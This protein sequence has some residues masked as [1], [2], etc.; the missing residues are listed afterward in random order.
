MDCTPN[1]QKKKSQG[2][3]TLKCSVIISYIV[4]I[5]SNVLLT[6]ILY[7]SDHGYKWPGYVFHILVLACS[8]LSLKNLL[9]FSKSNLLRYKSMTK[10]Y[11]ITLIITA[12]FYFIVIIYMFIS[13][14]DMDLIYYFTFCIIIWC[15]FHGLF[16]SIIN[17]FI[18]ALEDRPAQKGTNVKMID[19]NLRD[20]M[21][22]SSNAN[23]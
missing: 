5:T 19:K 11:S 7:L 21:L 2:C 14:T 22:S 8:F 17:S 15:I 13:Q 3:F 16:I 6:V 12:L 18:K 20:L 23:M 4:S 1:Q 10:Y 9:N